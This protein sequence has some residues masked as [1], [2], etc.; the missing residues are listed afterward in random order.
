MAYPQL[1]LPAYT[2]LAEY[3]RTRFCPGVDEV[4][5]ESITLLETNPR[6]IA[7]VHGRAQPRDEQGA[8]VAQLPHRRHGVRRGGSSGSASTTAPD[9]FEIHTWG[10]RS[11]AGR[12]RDD[13]PAQTSDPLGNLVLLLRG[14]LL[15]RYPRTWRCAVRAGDAAQ[16]E[17]RSRGPADAASSPAS[18]TRTCR[19]S[20]SRW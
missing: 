15:R 12:K 5:P 8:A 19:S 13:L 2:Y 7:G 10:S 17:R 11:V 9:I 16:A 6:F 3:D 20:A 18:S 14:D 1:D 4:P